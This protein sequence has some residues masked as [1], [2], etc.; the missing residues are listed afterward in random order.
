MGTGEPERIAEEVV[1]EESGLHVRLADL[2]VHG[3]ADVMGSHGIASSYAKRNAR[4]AARRSERTV[5]S[6]TI[7]RL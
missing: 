3:D 6:A 7:A 5:I 1:E 2:A 4:S